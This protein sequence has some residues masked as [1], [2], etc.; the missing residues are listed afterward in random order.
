MTTDTEPGT[1]LGAC[2]DGWTR[3][4][5]VRLYRL[6]GIE[7]LGTRNG[8]GLQVVVRGPTIHDGGAV[9]PGFIRVAEPNH[10]PEF[11]QP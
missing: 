2:R 8:I 5:P 7:R 4:S 11:V 9:L 3:P 6:V 1:R 10:V